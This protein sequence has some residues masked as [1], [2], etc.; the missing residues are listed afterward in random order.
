MLIESLKYKKEI[1]IQNSF[2]LFINNLEEIVFLIF[3]KININEFFLL[4]Q[5]EQK[6]KILLLSILQNKKK[7]NIS[8]MK[9]LK[10][11]INLFI[12]IFYLIDLKKKF[13]TNYHIS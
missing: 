8:F 5:W 2:E 6:D 12:F 7:I 3:K 9:C 13:V 4:N 10:K 11:I 1:I